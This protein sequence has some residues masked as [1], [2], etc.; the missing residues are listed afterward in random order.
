MATYT[1]VMDNQT[2]AAGAT[3]ILLRSDNTGSAGSI[4]E[5]CRVT[6]S[7][8]AEE[9]QQQL[10]VAMGRKV[11]AFGTYTSTT[12]TPHII[13]GAASG[14]TG[15]T[16][17]SVGTAGTDCSSEGGGALTVMHHEGFDNRA[18]YLWVPTPEERPVIMDGEAFAVKMTGTATSLGNWCA[19]LTY[20]EL[21]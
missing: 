1:V 16:D 19:T 11:T 8:L 4:L 13:G 17:G 2:I 3:L 18:G 20:N 6:V 9:V 12:P 5:I 7:Q 10:G 15:A 14:I 21:A